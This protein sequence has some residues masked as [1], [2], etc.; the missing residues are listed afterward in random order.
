MSQNDKL[1]SLSADFAG[2]S[3]LVAETKGSHPPGT[4]AY[5]A[6][7]VNAGTDVSDAAAPW[8]PQTQENFPRNHVRQ[9]RDLIIALLTSH[10]CEKRP[11]CVCVCVFVLVT[12]LSATHS[13]VLV[14]QGHVP[15]H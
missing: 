8:G 14:W 9:D 7:R 13:L 10:V 12:P 4:Q 11:R 3:K 6:F 1:C 2:V 5:D 15:L